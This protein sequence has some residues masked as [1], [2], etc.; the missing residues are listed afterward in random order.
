MFDTLTIKDFSGG[1]NTAQ[2]DTLIPS[3]MSGDMMDFEVT[4]IGTLRRRKGVSP[5]S[6]PVS[7]TIWAFD[8]LDKADGSSYLAVVSGTGMKVVSNDFVTYPPPVTVEAETLF[9]QVSATP[10]PY[11]NSDTYLSGGRAAV[12]TAPV[13]WYGGPYASIAATIPSCTTI[14]FTTTAAAAPEATGSYRVDAGSWISAT[15]PLGAL[16]STTV[17]SLAATEH[18]LEFKGH[19]DSWYSSEFLVDTITYSTDFTPSSP[20]T[21]ISASER[22]YGFAQLN[23]QLYYGSAYDD[24]KGY[25]GTT[26]VVTATGTS[27]GAFIVEHK[28][29][30]FAAGDARDRGIVNYTEPDDPNDY[31]QTAL[32]AG[33]LRF[34][35]DSGAEVK[36]MAIWNDIIF[37]ASDRKLWGLDVSDTDDANWTAKMLDEVGCSAPGTMIGMPNGVCFLSHDGLRAYGLINGIGSIDGAGVMNLS[38]NIQPTLATIT[39]YDLCCAAYYDDKIYL[40]VPLDGAD[41]PT[42]VLVCDMRRRTANGQP[43]WYPY[44]IPGITSMRVRTKG[45]EHAL[46]AGTSDGHMV[47]LESGDADQFDSG[48]A[49]EEIAAHYVIPPV[50]PSKRGFSDTIHYRAVH[51]ALDSDSTQNITVTP[52]TDDVATAAATVEVTAATAGRPLRIPVSARGRYMKLRIDAGALAP[53]SVNAVTYTFTRP[54]LR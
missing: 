41:S 48:D 30:L 3:N 49:P 43:V 5:H 53:L 42:H 18:V 33:V 1:W 39:R 45:N 47:I 12:C 14:S 31:S 22:T 27:R 38:V 19:G 40:S 10:A 16:A 24:V 28:R 51:A 35:K 46:Y 21:T 44:L 36:G 4:N 37:V 50:T 6:A 25:D 34:T 17:S 52:T 26:A 11:T 15:S 32:G 29:R 9:H 2:D 7:A 23:N 54:R 13:Y 20:D 8:W